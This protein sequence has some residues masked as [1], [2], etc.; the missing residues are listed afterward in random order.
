MGLG[1][2]VLW[3]HS[4]G[5]PGTRCGAGG[6]SSAVL[7]PLEEVQVLVTTSFE[8]MLHHHLPKTGGGGQNGLLLRN[9]D[10]KTASMGL[11]RQLM[12]T[13]MCGGSTGTRT[14]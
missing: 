1:T 11:A 3:G 7:L 14:G 6:P 13:C 4:W 2:D 10:I 12:V 9:K 8:S 5:A